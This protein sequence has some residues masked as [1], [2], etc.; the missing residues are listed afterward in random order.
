MPRILDWTPSG[1]SPDRPSAIE[2][3]SGP[4]SPLTQ[5]RALRIVTDPTPVTMSTCHR[6]GPQSCLGHRA[7]DKLVSLDLLQG[8]Q[9]PLNGRE[10]PS[11]P[12]SRGR[13]V[14]ER[15]DQKRRV[16]LCTVLRRPVHDAS[17]EGLA[18]RHLP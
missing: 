15:V 7:C 18:S 8:A 5:F 10:M 12:T 1:S 9:K 2:W 11:A 3:A 13:Q 6:T 16:V 14:V 4:T 17:A